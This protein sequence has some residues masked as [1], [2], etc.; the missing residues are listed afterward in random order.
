MRALVPHGVHEPGGLEDQQPG[1][2]DPDPR[3]G[4]PVLDHALL[5]ERAAERGPLRD[6]PAQQFQRPLGATDQP[7][8]V[9]DPARAEPGLGDGEPAALLADE[10]GGRHPDPVEHH[11]GVAAVRRVVVAEQPHAALDG[12][13][14]GVPGD[15]D[16]RLLP[17]PVGFG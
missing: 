15:Q 4:D 6:P 17:V 7:H 12:D 14:G 13:S 2:L 3:L 11:L 16:H 8:A 5:G 1:L 9:V 10:V